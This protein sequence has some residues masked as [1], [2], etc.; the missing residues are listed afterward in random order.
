MRAETPEVKIIEGR[1]KKIGSEPFTPRRPLCPLGHRE[2]S[3]ESDFPESVYAS[4]P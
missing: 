3:A 2:R 4:R 1:G